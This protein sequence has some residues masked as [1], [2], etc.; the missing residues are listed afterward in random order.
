MGGRHE[1]ACGLR[2]LQ[3]RHPVHGDKCAVLP[4]TGTHAIRPCAQQCHREWSLT[5]GGSGILSLDYRDADCDIASILITR[6]NFVGVVSNSIPAWLLNLTATEGHLSLPLLADG[7]A[8]GSN[9]FTLRLV[10]HRGLMSTASQFTVL[11]AGQ[12]A[13]GSAPTNFNFISLIPQ[14]NRPIR[15]ND[16]VRVPFGFSYHDADGD[17]ERVRLRISGPGGFLMASE[18]AASVYGIA[19]MDGV[20]TR[21]LLVFR[22]TNAVGTYTAQLTLIDRAGH[23]SA[24]ANTSVNLAAGHSGEPVPSILSFTPQAGGP[25]T[26]VRIT[27]DGCDTNA[28]ANTVQVGVSPVDVL[29][30]SR[31]NLVVLIP[32]GLN[33]GRFTVW[34]SKGRAVSTGIFSVPPSV[35]VAPESAKMRSRTASWG[36]SIS[37]SF[38][39]VE[40]HRQVVSERYGGHATDEREHGVRTCL[41]PFA[42]TREVECLQTE[43][44]ERGVATAEADHEEGARSWRDQPA[45]LRPGERGEEA[46]EE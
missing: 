3:I 30:A 40:D 15:A 10:D 45:A 7:L 41:E 39:G 32:K 38:R 9:V 43:R 14:W 12:G 33:A 4:A 46:D 36:T 11:P 17:I 8:F 44:G 13:G 31:T 35:E 26:Q 27:G 2:E 22:S 18:A 1:F 42:V 6:S 37:I 25:G 23:V 21:P 28:A 29:S 16:Y 19:G 24:I 5:F 34:N 20:A